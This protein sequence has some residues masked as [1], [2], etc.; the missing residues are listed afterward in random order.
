MKLKVKNMKFKVGGRSVLMNGEA[1]IEVPVPFDEISFGQKWSLECEGAM[2]ELPP[3]PGDKISEDFL[4]TICNNIVGYENKIPKTFYVGKLEF[5]KIKTICE[6]NAARSPDSPS[7]HL[8]GVYGSHRVVLGYGKDDIEM[9]EV[10]K[11]SY[12]NFSFY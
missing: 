5:A 2:S 3:A 1:F 7:Y 9:V 11:P 4:F 6:S 8:H 12:L 10:D